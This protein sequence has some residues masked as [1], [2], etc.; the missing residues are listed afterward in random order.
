MAKITLYE[1]NE[2]QVINKTG[3]AAGSLIACKDSANIYM[4]PTAGGTPIKM[5]ETIYYI[6]ES[7]RANILAPINGKSY[8]CYDTGKMW[9]YYNE[10]VCLNSDISTEFDIE[11]VELPSSGSVT[12]SDSRIKTTSTCTFIPD[13][14]VADLVSS[15]SVTAASGSATITG[16]T[17]CTIPGT[18]KV[19]N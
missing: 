8:F 4:V 6:T 7:A 9:V 11:N 1:L 12:V 10:W 15:V 3:L 14:S 19:K 5:A 18:L 13:L 17:S 16:T 2:S